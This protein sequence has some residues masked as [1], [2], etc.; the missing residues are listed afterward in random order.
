MTLEIEA[1]SPA[2]NEDGGPLHS[3]LESVALKGTYYVVFFY[4]AAMGL[5]LLS[6]VILSRLFLP[7]YF[8]LMALVTTVIVGMN[9]F[10]HV[11][12]QDSVIQNPRGDEP[13]FLNTAWTIQVMRG[14]GLFL[15]SIPLAWPVARFYREPEIVALLP[16]LGFSCL[17]SGFSS[18][19]LLTLARHLGVGRL[20]SL[21][22]V[23]QFI[24]LVVTLV[25]ALIQ[26]TIWALVAGRL[27]SELARTVIS[28]W[29]LP[30]MR[31]RFTWDKECVHILIKFGRW[32][33]IGTA[34][35]FLALQSDRLILAKL[36]S[37]QLLG[38]YGIAFSLSDIPR[39]I[40]LQFCTRIGYPFIAKFS[41]RPRTEYRSIFLRY[42]RPVLAVG[43]LLIIAVVLTGDKFILHV[44]TKPYHGAAWMIPILAVG[45][46]HTLLYSTTSPAVFSLQKSHYNA[47]A[48]LLYCI[49]LYI[50]LPV[51]FHWMGMTGAVIAVAVSDLPVYFVTAY[52][53]V[54]EGIGTLRQDAL[55]T[56]AFVASLALA[57]AC[58]MWLGFGWPF[59]HLP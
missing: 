35:T 48:Y 33:L 34:L 22:L 24:Q 50:A 43:G 29:I 25:W 49:M 38:V 56:L 40:I 21:E 41:D 14:I 15:V 57:L 23:T 27:A 8:G 5:R 30:E 9:L 45:L 42:R 52:G 39:Q 19:S 18:T 17:I 12:L 44:Y 53:A 58:R 4:G 11:G 6:S 59:P 31:P 37:F 32:I 55:L 16:A 3:S 46:W 2:M 13:V 28:F 26:P 1:P 51:S 47:F 36:V 54:R 7:Q 10:S 20:S